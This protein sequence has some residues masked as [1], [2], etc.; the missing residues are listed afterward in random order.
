MRVEVYL[1][2]VLLRVEDGEFNGVCKCGQPATI[3]KV[4]EFGTETT[5]VLSYTPPSYYCEP[6]L[7]PTWPCKSCNKRTRVWFRVGSDSLPFCDF[8][9]TKRYA[10]VRRINDIEEIETPKPCV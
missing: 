3:K 5:R 6:C 9:C 4:Y 2:D 7:Y 1:N 10:K 8:E